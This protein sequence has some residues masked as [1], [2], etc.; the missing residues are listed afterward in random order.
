MYT[1]TIHVYIHVNLSFLILKIHQVS[2]NMNDS[3]SKRLYGVQDLAAML[4][5][6]IS[7]LGQGNGNDEL[8]FSPPFSL[9][10]LQYTYDI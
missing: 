3:H 7:P 5:G 10:V 4:L 9:N 8:I 1:L 6:K 2:F